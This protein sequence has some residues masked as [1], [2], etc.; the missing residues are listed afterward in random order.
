MNAA[1]QLAGMSVAEVVVDR[2]IVLEW[3]DGPL[4]GFARLAAVDAV[5]HFRVI[6]ER[7]DADFP[8]DRLYQFSQVATDALDR[9]DEA[10]GGGPGDLFWIPEWA[11]S[12][13]A[14]RQHADRLVADL[15]DHAAGR[16]V[17]IRSVDLRV[18][19]ALWLATGKP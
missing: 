10:L 2:A 15:I 7:T 1:Q 3:Y 8:D 12:D 19:D 13:H 11:F 9:L 17:F 18:V 16:R 5:W 6:A 4:E 14:A